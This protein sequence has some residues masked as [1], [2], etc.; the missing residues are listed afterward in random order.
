M[1]PSTEVGTGVANGRTLAVA[2]AKADAPHHDADIQAPDSPRSIFRLFRSNVGDLVA[3]RPVGVL[4]G[5]GEGR[6]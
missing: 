4:I 2:G 6:P 1:T 5:I 3:G